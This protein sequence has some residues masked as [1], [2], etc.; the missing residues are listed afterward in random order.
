MPPLQIEHA[1]IV[2]KNTDQRF[3]LVNTIL[4]QRLSCSFDLAKPG[5]IPQDVVKLADAVLAATN[6]A[7][8]LVDKVKDYAEAMA[9]EPDEN[10]EAKQPDTGPPADVVCVL[11]KSALERI[12]ADMQTRL[13]R[14]AKIHA[15]N[16]TTNVRAQ[17]YRVGYADCSKNTMAVI[18]EALQM[19]GEAENA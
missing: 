14:D 11:E 2:Q 19:Q 5:T 13:D 15:S 16:P 6:K 3:E 4:N 8:S 9:T 18:D 1:M 12:R 7:D 17:G 10:P